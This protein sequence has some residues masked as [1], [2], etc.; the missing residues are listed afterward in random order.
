M[1]FQ[2]GYQR[3]RCQLAK[4]NKKTKGIVWLVGGILHWLLWFSPTHWASFIVPGDRQDEI[5]SQIRPA[6]KPVTDYF[7][8]L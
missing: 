4:I 8:A 1:E 5:P 7:R 2:P 3:W 6:R